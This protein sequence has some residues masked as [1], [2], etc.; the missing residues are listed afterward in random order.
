MLR[1][2]ELAPLCTDIAWSYNLNPNLHKRIFDFCKYFHNLYG[3]ILV[4]ISQPRLI[5]STI[6]VTYCC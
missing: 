2:R 5:I 1:Y 3:V 6:A 4:Y